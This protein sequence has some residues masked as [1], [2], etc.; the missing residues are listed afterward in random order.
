MPSAYDCI[1][2]FEQQN[3]A[4]LEPESKKENMF[5][6]KLPKIGLS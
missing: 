2:W 5:E 6:T 4:Q 1:C 3:K